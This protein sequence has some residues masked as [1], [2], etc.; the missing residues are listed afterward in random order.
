MTGGAPSVGNGGS[1]LSNHQ[2]AAPASS[3]ATAATLRRAALTRTNPRYPSQSPISEAGTV[4]QHITAA[5]AVVASVSARFAAVFSYRLA[6]CP[7]RG[8]RARARAEQRRDLVGHGRRREIRGRRPL[9]WG[10]A[11]FRRGRGTIGPHVTEAQL[12]I[13]DRGPNGNATAMVV[14]DG[15]HGHSAHGGGPG[16]GHRRAGGLG[17]EPPA[18]A[19][20][21]GREGD[22]GRRGDDAPAALPAPGRV[23]P[24]RSRRARPGLAARGGRRGAL[25]ARRA[26]GRARALE[27]E[28]GLPRLRA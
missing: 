28:E 8:R 27:R 26:A 4:A 14:D 22:R 21:G 10:R 19:R 20:A 16:D 6:W 11:S 23:D 24:P 5:G 7:C 17:P 15:P 3:S 2:A 12:L 13:Q 9:R 18:R 1:A 25:R